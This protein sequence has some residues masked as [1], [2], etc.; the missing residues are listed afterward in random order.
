MTDILAI[1]VIVF[2]MF[3]AI[4]TFLQH[5]LHNEKHKKHRKHKNHKNHKKH[6][7]HNKHTKTK[8]RIDNKKYDGDK[9]KRRD[10]VYLDITTPNTYMGKIIV[11]LFTDVT[12]YTCENF[13]ILC[14]SKNI[15]QSYRGSKFH[16]SIPGFV[17]QGGKLE[18]GPYSI[19]GNSFPDENFTLK[20][21]KPG[22]LS[23][24]NHGPD[25]NG[26]QFFI[27]LDKA[28]HL[29][30][31]HV[32]FGKVIKGFDI[33]E[34]IAEIRTDSQDKP[35]TDVMIKKCGLYQNH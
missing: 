33:V 8:K 23:M 34:K 30:G 29:D 35:T 17:I 22:L 18:G 28:D 20:H 3:I 4:E 27:T 31:K 6:K 11:E 15:K 25:T 2:V 24:A 7:K 16:R 14:S 9:H 1:L 32:V 12:P 5:K 19:Y 13:K 21:D 10:Y 26:S